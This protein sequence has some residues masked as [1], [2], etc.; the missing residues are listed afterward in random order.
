[1]SAVPHE[2]TLSQAGPA[3]LDEVMALEAE[4]FQAEVRES[5]QA[6][7]RRLAVFPQGFL[8]LRHRPTGAL[9]GCI[10]SELW[11]FRLQPDAAGFALGHDIA[12]SHRPDGRELYLSS[13]TVG[14]AWR[15]RGLGRVLLQ[16]CMQAVRR[17]CPHVDSALLIVHGDWLAA[18][19]LYETEGFEDIGR[20]AGFFAST[21]AKA[22]DA[23][24]MR[25]PL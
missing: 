20:L 7:E 24:V 10:T 1:M 2:M 16:G 21:G 15:G 8:V 19:R 17:A 13:T 12:S 23:I 3:D 18:R 22:G 25:R 9:A 6:F 4:G 5:R 14:A 11:T